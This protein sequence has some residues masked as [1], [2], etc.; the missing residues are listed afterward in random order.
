V[1]TKK[2]SETILLTAD[3]AGELQAREHIVSC[4]V[5]AVS[6]TGEGYY[7]EDFDLA[8]AEYVGVVLRAGGEEIQYKALPVLGRSTARLIIFG[9]E[10]EAPDI[11]DADSVEDGNAKDVDEQVVRVRATGGSEGDEYRILF[12]ATTNYGNAYIKEVVIGVVAD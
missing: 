3:F 7:S 1:I 5:N 9:G 10:E 11:I 2:V 12:T 4:S 8:S 6:C